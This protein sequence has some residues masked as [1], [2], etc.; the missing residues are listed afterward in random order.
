[1]GARPGGLPVRTLKGV[2]LGEGVCR[3]VQPGIGLVGSQRANTS[4]S[5]YPTAGACDG[6]GHGLHAH[7]DSSGGARAAALDGEGDGNG[8]IVGADRGRELLQLAQD[9]FQLV[10]VQPLAGVEV[11]GDLPSVHGRTVPDVPTAHGLVG[12]R[13]PST[14]WRGAGPPPPVHLMRQNQATLDTPPTEPE[15]TTSA[16]AAAPIVE[17]ESKPDD[18]DFDYSTL[19]FVVIRG[20]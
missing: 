14:R 15:K 10:V 6:P 9:R 1:M 20:R 19:D 16:S 3:F 2:V 18:R 12:L 17:P 5:G 13:S 11:G 4:L 7:L 8:D